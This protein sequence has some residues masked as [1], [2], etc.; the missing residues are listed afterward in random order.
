MNILFVGDTSRYHSGCKA[1][2]EVI[3]E[4][5][6]EHEVIS[7]STRHSYPPV[8]WNTVDLVLCN[9]E[10]TMHH[11]RPAACGTMDLLREAQ[12]NNVDT[13]LINTVW[14]QMTGYEDVI[15]RLKLFIVREALSAIH[16][17]KIH[18]DLSYF[19][20]VSIEP[21]NVEP[22]VGQFMRQES[23]AWG[24]VYCNIF[25]QTWKELLD[26]IADAPW[27][28]TGRHHEIYAC[29]RTQ[30]AFVP[31]PSNS[32][33]LEGLFYS[34]GARLEIPERLLS[35]QECIEYVSSNRDEY[36]KIFDWV[37][38]FSTLDI[39]ENLR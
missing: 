11:N 25:K 18:P 31:Y 32:H 4:Q 38:S 2:V 39:L 24:K 12:H 5:L 15:S 22:V 17:A 29:L 34:A 10:G 37:E 13:A 21:Y 19:K 23:P 36:A 7:I 27:V 28:Y 16:N 1:V 6:Q 26:T 3:L 20:K 30:T 14:Q 35:E 8:D 9:G 33:K